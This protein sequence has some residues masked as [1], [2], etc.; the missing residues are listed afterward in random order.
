MSLPS[1]RPCRRVRPKASRAHYGLGSETGNAPGRL[2][3]RG[4][5]SLEGTH[6]GKVSALSPPC[7]ASPGRAEGA[8]ETNSA[9]DLSP[10]TNGIRGE[11][12]DRGPRGR[13]V[14][15]GRGPS[16]GSRGEG[17]RTPGP[18]QQQCCWPPVTL[19]RPPPSG[20]GRGG[21]R[22][23]RAS[24]GPIFPTSGSPALDLGRLG[25]LGCLG[26]L[27]GCLLGVAGLPVWGSS[28]LPRAL[29]RCYTP[30]T[31]RAGSAEEVRQAPRAAAS[32][33]R[34][35]GRSSAAPGPTPA[36]R[37]GPGMAPRQQPARTDGEWAQGAHRQSLHT[38][39]LRVGLRTRACV[40]PP[41]SGPGVPPLPGPGQAGPGA[42]SPQGWGTAGSSERRCRGSA[43][44]SA[45]ARP[46]A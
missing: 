38:H 35:G 40:T 6:R 15:A 36:A 16:A 26:C 31:A 45:G 7:R 34:G 25:C 32:E 10:A 17:P 21:G 46:A 19:V 37:R 11:A 18:G 29:R 39:P 12:L 1:R 44:V 41:G 5:P 3:S 23:G 43:G 42:L 2:K 27:L 14:R 30:L 4:A 20:R 33:R 24:R 28:A 22:G 9:P 13:N 8:D